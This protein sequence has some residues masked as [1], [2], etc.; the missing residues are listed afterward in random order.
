[1]V[2]I[3]LIPFSWV[4][5]NRLPASEQAGHTIYTPGTTAR[6]LSGYT[7][8]ISYGDG[9]GA[10]GIVYTDT[11]NVSFI[12]SRA[13]YFHLTNPDWRRHR[14]R[15]SRRGC[16]LRQLRVRSGCRQRSGRTCLQLHQYR[17]AHAAK[18][19]LRQRQGFPPI[20]RLDR[21]PQEGRPR[22]LQLRLHRLHPVHRL[23]YLRPRQHRQ[24]LLGIYRLRL[25]RW[26]RVFRLDLHQR[27][28][29]YRHHPHLR[30]CCGRPGLLLQGFR[31]LQ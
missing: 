31:L 16:H 18:D 17:L 2:L 10:A 9:S 12:F 3:G 22:Y 13:P 7:W 28:R 20:P 4:F 24:R 8:D 11:V 27:H 29:R 1:M 5:S 25:R 15:P 19:L 30:S 6:Q 26:L 14:H 23:H 21:Q